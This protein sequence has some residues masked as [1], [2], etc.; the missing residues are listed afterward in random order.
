EGGPERLTWRSPG[1]ERLPPASEAAGA[2]VRNSHR[3]SSVQNATFS[4]I[5]FEG[6]DP[7]SQAG[8]LG[9]RV[10]GLVR[11]LAELRLETHLF[12]IGDPHRPGE[13]GM[14]DDRL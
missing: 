2:A 5:S 10:S 8:G 1:A 13:E 4:I 6:T 11:T 7:Y 12:F 14:Y 9:V 3:C